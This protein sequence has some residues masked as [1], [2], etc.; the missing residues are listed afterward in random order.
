MNIKP[1]IKEFV[2][3]WEGSS[4]GIGKINKW[5]T[6]IIAWGSKRNFSKNYSMDIN[7]NARLYIKYQIRRNLEIYYIFVDLILYELR[8]AD[9]DEL[10]IEIIKIIVGYTQSINCYNNKHW[11]YQR[12]RGLYAKELKREKITPEVC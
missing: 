6:T 4:N 3:E 9:E 1:K 11:M 2:E 7:D 10:E 12:L 5:D 8:F